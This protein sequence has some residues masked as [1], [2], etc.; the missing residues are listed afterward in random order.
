MG[1]RIAT[2]ALSGD[3]SGTF[4]LV[5]AVEESGHPAMGRDLGEV[6]ERGRLGVHVTDQLSEPLKD[7]DV[8]IEFTRPEATLAH[9]QAAAKLKKAVVIGTT[10]FDE[11]GRQAIETA[12]RSIPIVFSPNMSLGVNLLFELVQLAAERLGPDYG[13]K[14]VESHHKGKKDAPSGT[15]K[16][17]Q[18]VIGEVRQRWHLGK[19]VP[20]ESI[21]EGEI[22]GDHT[23][24]FSGKFEVLELTHRAMNRDVF[25]LGALQAAG[26]AAKQPAALYDMSDVLKGSTHDRDRARV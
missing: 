16:R 26:F 19:E 23:V 18:E 22:V 10:G 8:L 7:A 12:A 15:A 20:C 9:L 3:L 1:S 17:L 14:I 11:R 13:V 24:T 5:G 4:Q 25:A 21:R 2:L 6:L